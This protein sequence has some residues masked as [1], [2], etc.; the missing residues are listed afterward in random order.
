MM[1]TN[2]CA[3]SLGMAELA[4]GPSNWKRNWRHFLEMHMLPQGGERWYF[5]TMLENLCHSVDFEPIEEP[6]ST[7]LPSTL[8]GEIVLLAGDDAKDL[9]EQ[10][11]KQRFRVSHTQTAAD[12]RVPFSKGVPLAAIIDMDF[13]EG[14]LVAGMQMMAV[15]ENR[16]TVPLLFMSERGD[17]AG[18]MEA[19]SAGGAAYLVKP[20]D[21]VAVLTALTDQLWQESTRD[22]AVLI[23][24]D[25]PVEAQ[26]I[27]TV[28]IAAGVSSEV[29][30]QPLEALQAIQNRQP[31]VLVLDLDLSTVDGLELLPTLRQTYSNLTIIGCSLH[32]EP[33]RNQLV[34]AAGGDYLL[35]KSQ[36][37]SHLLSA[38]RHAIHRHLAQRRQ[39][40]HMLQHDTVSGLYNRRYFLEGLKQAVQVDQRNVAVLLIT[41]DNLRA[42]EAKDAAAIDD[43]VAEAATR[44]RSVLKPGQQAARF[45]DAAFIVLSEATANE[46]LLTTARAIRAALE[47]DAFAVGD[48]FMQL[49]TSIG[50]SITETED[51]DYQELLL[52]AQQAC[53]TAW[54]AKGDRVM[55]YEPSDA[56]PVTE[57]LHHRRL[58][59]EIR[60]ALDQQ[61]M[62][63]VF[64]PIA[65]LRNDLQERYEVWLRIRNQDGLELLPETVFAATQRHRLGI[66]LDRWVITRALRLLQK[67]HNQGQ[68]ITLFI[69]ISPT[70]LHDKEFTDWLKQVLENANLPAQGLVFEMPE[71]TAERYF[72]AL[73][74]FMSQVKP[75]GCGFSLD[76]FGNHPH[77]LALLKSLGM[78]YAKLDPA[79]TRD[80][81]DDPEKQAALKELVQQL[82]GFQITVV[83]SHIEDSSTLQTLSACGISAVQGF[84][85]KTARSD[86]LQFQWQRAGV[87]RSAFLAGTGGIPIAGFAGSRQCPRPTAQLGDA[88]EGAVR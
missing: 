10:L 18:R 1:Y 17:L 84:C 56:E 26:R 81:V 83:A 35:N 78:D 49:R 25:N 4:I 20:V 31:S 34:L 67:R 15:A 76:G 46:S 33:D 40:D 63:L 41:L 69:N 39:L 68:A 80:L 72:Q 82:S 77:S 45:T 11:T 88:F 85:C 54:V 62:R 48:A 70:L 32:T 55:I 6:K 13:P 24:T 50:I 38:L 21:T 65:S 61:R 71:S 87:N 73:R 23:V 42:M 36:L 59:D 28:M 3:I 37:D 74:K 29:V 8:K 12:F 7:Q 2:W 43:V 79:L 30:E 57:A 14:A 64:Q 52:Q 27:T 75:L 60:E 53:S 86:G 22:A 44:L 16:L 19:V 58:L 47:T 66:R 5:L 9:A 51:S